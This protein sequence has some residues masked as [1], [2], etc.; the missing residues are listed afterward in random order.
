MLE[1]KGGPFIVLHFIDV[2]GHVCSFIVYNNA[3]LLTLTT[4]D[5][6]IIL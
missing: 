2:I 1:W 6:F 5:T 3:L 4:S